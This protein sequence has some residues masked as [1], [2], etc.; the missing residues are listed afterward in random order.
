MKKVADIMTKEVVSVDKNS[1]LRH[2]MDLM[3]KHN[4]TKLP[5]MDNDELVGIVTDNMIADELG[6][7][8]GRGIP[9]ERLH[10]SSVMSKKFHTVSPETLIEELLK[11]VGEPGITMIPVT[12]A[13]ELVGVVTKAD[14]LPFVKSNGKLSG[15]MARNLLAVSPDDRVVHARRI[16]LDKDV[17]RLPVLDGG[18]LV[19]II[20]DKEIAFALA[21]LKKAHPANHQSHRIKEMLVKDIMY[22]NV[23]TGTP[24][25]TL[26]DA[27]RLMHERG[28]GSLPLM[29]P[30]GRI[31]GMITRT[32]LLKSIPI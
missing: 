21:D 28:V 24:D 10:A 31:V 5:V 15:I 30:D 7:L 29:E 11:S 9:A 2:V 3:I 4:I 1:E 12:Y 19:G 13:N 14:I 26:A 25:M 20:A 16:M 22:T 17:A 32:D 8:K 6:S 23:V 18:K 27:A